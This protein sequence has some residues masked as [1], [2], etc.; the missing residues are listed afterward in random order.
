MGLI[1]LQIQLEIQM[2]FHENSVFWKL[3]D[4]PQFLTSYNVVDN[5]IKEYHSAGLGV[6]RSSDII[7]L[8]SE[9]K[10]YNKDVL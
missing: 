10:L 1:T 7:T 2:Y 8:D 9:D 5:I 4:Q 3:L 6:C